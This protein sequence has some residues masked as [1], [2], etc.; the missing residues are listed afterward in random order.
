MKKSVF[1][2]LA[3]YLISSLVFINASYAHETSKHKNKNAEKPKCAAMKNMDH[4]KMDENDPIMQAMMQQC[5]GDHHSDAENQEEH[6]KMME[7]QGK[8]ND[9]N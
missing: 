1:K 3:A 8:E 4:S 5:M 7:D 2:T 6:K 9:K